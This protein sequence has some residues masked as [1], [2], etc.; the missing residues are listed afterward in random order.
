[1]LDECKLINRKSQRIRACTLCDGFLQYDLS[2]IIAVQPFIN[3][4]Q[5]LISVRV[6][7]I[8]SHGL[9]GVGQCLLM[10]PYTF[11][12]QRQNVPRN[13]VSWIGSFPL[14]VDLIVLIDIHYI[15]IIMMNR[16]IKL[17]SHSHT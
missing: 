2:F 14:I 1:M 6:S 5:V 11:V 13:S 12:T 10:L 8:E 17:S 3:V 9:A 7:W 16:N 15:F 4:P